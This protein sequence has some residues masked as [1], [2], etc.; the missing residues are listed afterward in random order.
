M[1]EPTESAL[2]GARFPAPVRPAESW[3]H[4]DTAVQLSRIA[5]RGLFASAPVAAGTVVCRLG[6][7][8]VSTAELKALFET[9]DA[10]VD[11]IVVDV[12]VHLLLPAGDLAHF[13][14]HSCEPNLGWADEYTLVALRDIAAGDELTD[15]YATSTADPAFVLMCHC[16]TYRCRQVIEGTDWQIPQLQQ[17]Y[18]GHW[19]P[20]LQR[21]ID[22]AA[23]PRP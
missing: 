14:N 9:S 12:D 8:L 1:S 2:P 3:V 10:Y 22:A 19:V 7:R 21:L 20:Y 6:G 18:A 23:G 16:E 13:T 4:P 17:R 15:D 11:S 5:G